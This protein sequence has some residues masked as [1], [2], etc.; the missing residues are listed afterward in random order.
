MFGAYENGWP[1]KQGKSK[2]IYIER[3]SQAFEINWK[4]QPLFGAVNPTT[5]NTTRGDQTQVT[6]LSSDGRV[7]TYAV[8][9]TNHRWSKAAAYLVVII[10]T[11]SGIY[12]NLKWTLL[13]YAPESRATMEAKSRM[14]SYSK[15]FLRKS[16]TL[17]NHLKASIAYSSTQQWILSGGFLGFS[18]YVKKKIVI[19]MINYRIKM[20]KLLS[21]LC[22]FL[23]HILSIDYYACKFVYSYFYIYYLQI[24][25]K[26]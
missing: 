18:I 4:G 9:P 10:F 7:R 3:E 26:R 16:K 21:S 24:P 6:T 20:T 15:L 2:K 12:A 14:V 8:H 25:L 17:E 13:P 5:L 1:Q 11:N 22:L 19:K 23:T